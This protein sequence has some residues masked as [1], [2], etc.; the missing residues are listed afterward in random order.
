METIQRTAVQLCCRREFIEPIRRA[1]CCCNFLA[2]IGTEAYELF[3]TFVFAEPDHSKD[4]DKV[5][6]AFQK[7]C[8]GETNITFERYVF[9]RRLQDA[10]ESF[11]A[12]L[13]ELRRLIRTC[14]YGTIEESI[15]RDRI[16]IGIR[17]DPTRRRLLQTRNLD[18]KTAIDI[19]KS[20][21]SA[22]KQLKTITAPDELNRLDAKPPKPRDASRQS[23]RRLHSDRGSRDRSQP[24]CCLLLQS[25]S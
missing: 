22:A 2:C 12:Y 25:E 11:D 8:I 5:V 16:V 7:H 14:D 19:C 1:P 17:D 13:S 6:E 24:R 10:S 20:C 4:I 3:Q 21:E 23:N 9:N 18:L 15:L